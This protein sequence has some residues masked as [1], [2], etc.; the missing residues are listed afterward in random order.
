VTSQDNYLAVYFQRV[1]LE[2]R[3]ELS[4]FSHAQAYALM[5]NRMA[6]IL[7]GGGL[8]SVLALKAAYNFDFA[9]W[10]SETFFLVCFGLGALCA[11]I[12]MFFS[13]RNLSNLATMH[14]IRA[15]RSALEVGI[16]FEKFDRA[17]M[18]KV[19]ED[20]TSL[21]NEKSETSVYISLQYKTFIFTLLAS[22]LSFLFPF[23][24]S[25]FR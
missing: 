13:F 17:E 4:A 25:I 20:L 9:G 19:D 18:Q 3:Q 8:A 15:E 11:L 7:N 10:V 1:G 21:N 6:V 12:S 14:S 23:I 24:V 5:G 2:I 22:Y 16:E